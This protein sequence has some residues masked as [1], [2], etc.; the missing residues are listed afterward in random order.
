MRPKSRFPLWP[1]A[2]HFEKNRRRGRFHTGCDLYKLHTELEKLLFHAL[3]NAQARG[4]YGI[5]LTRCDIDDDNPVFQRIRAASHLAERRIGP[6]LRCAFT[7]GELASGVDTRQTAV[8]IHATL[9]GIFHKE[10]QK[11]QRRPKID[12]GNIIDLI[13][14][15]LKYP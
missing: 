11:K 8:F 6:V 3:H 4:L 7:L 15:C 12:A 14:Q 1:R 2:N 5:V 13:F 9:T 10:L